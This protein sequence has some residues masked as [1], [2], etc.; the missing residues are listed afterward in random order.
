M[1]K[2][3]EVAM[4]HADDPCTTRQ[5]THDHYERVV[6]AIDIVH[7]LAFAITIPV[8]LTLAILVTVTS[9]QKLAGFLV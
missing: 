2:N 6:L 3:V 8:A 7:R 4:I 5:R 9:S 1:K